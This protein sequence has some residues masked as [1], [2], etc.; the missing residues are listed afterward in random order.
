MRGEIAV[1]SPLVKTVFI[2][3]LNILEYGS[4]RDPLYSQRYLR[5]TCT[6][7]KLYTGLD[8]RPRLAHREVLWVTMMV[9]TVVVEGLGQCCSTMDGDGGWYCK[10][11][12]CNGVSLSCRVVH[13]VSVY[14]SQAKSNKTDVHK[15]CGTKK[16]KKHI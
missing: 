7:A 1:S 5:I 8:A 9:W 3:G 14:V 16:T 10:G 2:F 11:W 13:V 4:A 15:W 6:Q 12:S